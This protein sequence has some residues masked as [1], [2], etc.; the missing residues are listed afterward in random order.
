M[1]AGDRSSQAVPC[2]LVT[3]REK[4]GIFFFPFPPGFSTL[5]TSLPAQPLAWKQ[6]GK[7]MGLKT[8]Y[9]KVPNT[10]YGSHS[11]GLHKR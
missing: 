6:L 3:G 9:T 7:V 4:Q 8:D 10:F 1:A 11:P 5:H 2:G